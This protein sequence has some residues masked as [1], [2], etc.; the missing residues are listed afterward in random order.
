MQETKLTGRIQVDDGDVQLVQLE[1]ASIA[2]YLAT[3]NGRL[4]HVDVREAKRKRTAKQNAMYWPAIVRA[5]QGY[6]KEATG[7]DISEAR[8][9]EYNLQ[10]VLGMEPKTIKMGGIKEF[11]TY[12]IS[13]D[14]L[15]EI[16]SR[17]EDSYGVV[18]EKEISRSSDMSTY[19]YSVLIEACIRHYAEEYGWELK[20]SPH[21]FDDDP[22]MKMFK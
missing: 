2:R 4:V 8:V 6:H 9:H 22:I 3:Y 5:V 13:R 12:D 20:L 11:T 7:E 15:D 21:G 18:I 1:P 16:A 10:V 19:M 17:L 14:R